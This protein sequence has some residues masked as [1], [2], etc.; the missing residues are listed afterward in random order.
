MTGALTLSSRIYCRLLDFYPEDL[1]RKFGAEM[2]GLFA[3]DLDAAR[4][5]AGVLGVIRVWR[6]ALSEFLRFALPSC[7][8]RPA[9]RVPA[10]SCG[11]FI[12]LMSGE[13]ALRQASHAPTLPQAA[14]T[15]LWLPMFTTP[16]IA[17]AAVWTCRSRAV[18]S[19]GLSGSTEKDD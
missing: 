5:E 12:A 3:E 1:R 15:A 13:M 9:V 19:L 6:C 18:I 14:F 17:L 4:R 8:S 10:I 11:L 7:A 16:F 2:A